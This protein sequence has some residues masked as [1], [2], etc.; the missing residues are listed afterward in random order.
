VSS[1]L[2]LN[3]L[4]KHFLWIDGDEDAAASRQNFSLFVQNLSAI[5]VLAAVYADLPA[6][7]VQRFMKR[8]RLQIFDGHFFGES[9]DVMELVYLSHRI[10]QDGRDNAS[11]TVAGWSG[12]ALAQPKFA[13]ER[14]PF[15]VQRELQPH[16]VR[17]I[18]AAREA[19]IFLQLVVRRFVAVN[20]AGHDGDSNASAAKPSPRIPRLADQNR[21]PPA[22]DGSAVQEV[23]S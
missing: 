15:P 19:V 20:L 3:K 10:V 23:I 9:D 22:S 14:L 7:N 2:S 11:V 4:P 8:H 21:E 16:A 18:H 12:V 6:F 13:N 5:D 1:Q 17:I